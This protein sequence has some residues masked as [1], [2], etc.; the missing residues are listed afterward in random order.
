MPH[1]RF[2]RLVTTSDDVDQSGRE[3]SFGRDLCKQQ[4]GQRRGRGRFDH[5]RVPHRQSGGYLPCQHQQRKVP[6]NNLPHNADGLIVGQLAAHDL[7]PAS[8]MIKVACHQRHIDVA[9]FADRFAVVQR[10]N[11]GQQTVMFLDAAR[12]GVQHFGPLMIADFGPDFLRFFG[13]F[14]SH[15][16]ISFSPIHHMCQR[17]TRCG[18]GHL[19]HF[20]AIRCHK[21]AVDKEAEFSTFVCNPLFGSCGRFWCGSVF[22]GVKNFFY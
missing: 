1:N 6:R 11:H 22:H 19:K 17:F 16:H 10:L 3:S 13:R 12:N 20:G 5:N 2:A 14:K 18:G 8:M 7:C 4:G 9:R 15:R 21:L